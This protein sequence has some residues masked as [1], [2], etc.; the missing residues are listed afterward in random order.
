MILGNSAIAH[1]ALSSGS[2]GGLGIPSAT[3]TFSETTKQAPLKIFIAAGDTSFAFAGKASIGDLRLPAVT[4]GFDENTSGAP[5]IFSGTSVAA[6]TINTTGTSDDILSRVKKLIPGR[7]FSWVAPNRDAIIGALADSAAWNYK[8]IKYAKAQTRLFTAY[9]IWLD[10]FSYDYLARHLN[11]TSGESDDVFRAKI[12]A[13][14]LQERVTRA[15][16][17]AA[18]TQFTGQAP[19]IFEPWNTNDTG[20]YSG[21]GPGATYG[22]FGYGVG[23]GGYGNMNLPCQTF[24]LVHKGVGAG[25]PGIGGYG[26]SIQGY[27]GGAGEYVGPQSE[28]SGITEQM[29]YDMI[30]STKPTGT[31]C[32]TQVVV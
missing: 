22:S 8:F 15:G 17:K 32:W 4:A 25:V 20:A 9:G 18:L 10:I 12:R 23:Q 3:G 28:E 26:S 2:G 16:M 7:W 27:G 11:R 14:I 29:V 19:W 21:K 13:T 30:D 31:T 5:L 1:D 6:A 24:M